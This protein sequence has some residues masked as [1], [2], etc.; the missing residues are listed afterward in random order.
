MAFK[1]S[2]VRSRLSPPSD[3]ALSI[4][5]YWTCLWAGFFV[6]RERT[7]DLLHFNHSRQRRL[8]GVYRR[9][10][11]RFDP[12]YLHQKST[13]S[14]LNRCFF[15]NFFRFSVLL[16]QRKSQQNQP[17]L[18]FVPSKGGQNGLHSGKVKREEDCFLQIQGLRGSGRQWQADFQ[19]YDL[20]SPCGT[21][22]RKGSEGSPKGGV[23]L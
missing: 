20:V 5:F 23:Y 17:F 14:T 22:A 19:V 21:H 9:I 4:L 11:Q 12:T 8:C 7:A 18:P 16:G 15:S 1:R 10:G 3:G 13:D 6:M 2:A